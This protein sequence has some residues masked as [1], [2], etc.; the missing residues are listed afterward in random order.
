MYT[1]GQ[2]SFHFT[3]MFWGIN[4]KMS[5]MCFHNAISEIFPMGLDQKT[6]VRVFLHVRIDELSLFLQGVSFENFRTSPG[7]PLPNSAV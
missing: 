4:L 1:Q 3:E 6:F 7:C 5:Y 2:Y